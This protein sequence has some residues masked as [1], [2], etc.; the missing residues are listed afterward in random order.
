VLEET[1]YKRTR[2]CEKGHEVDGLSY[3][4]VQEYEFFLSYSKSALKKDKPT[5]RKTKRAQRVSIEPVRRARRLFSF[6]Q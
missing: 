5:P 1:N 6:N 2:E 3:P 4:C